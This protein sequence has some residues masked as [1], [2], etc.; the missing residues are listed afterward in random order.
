MK[1]KIK[2]IGGVAFVVLCFSLA[3]LNA[4][5]TL[6][7]QE[8]NRRINQAEESFMDKIYSEAFNQYSLLI[9][10]YEDV[11]PNKYLTE[12]QKDKMSDIYFN[13]A[14]CAYYLMNNDVDV[15]FEQ[16]R[17]LFPNSQ[18]Q[19]KAIFYVANWYIQKA[20]Y[21]K[22]LKTYRSIDAEDL[23]QEEQLEYYYKIGYCY[24]L[25]NDVSKAKT[26]FEKVK[27]SKSKYASPSK[28]Y[29]AH[30]LYQEGKY[31]LA[32]K[33][34]ETLRTNRYFKN[35]VPYYI[36]QIYYFQEKYDDIINLAPTLSKNAINSKRAIEL[37]RMLGD[38]YYKKGQYAQAKEYI[39][40]SIQ[41]SKAVNKEDN[42]LMGYCLMQ[43][44][45]TK[46][47]IDYFKQAAVDSDTLGQNALYYL[48]YCYLQNHDT[49]LAKNAYKGASDMAF[50]KS[51]QED[52]MFTY[53]KL[54]INDPGPYNEAIKYFSTYIKKFPKS[55][56]KA[57]A[58]GYLVQLYER[59]KNY[60]DA[61][62]LL[63][64]M[65]Q[66]DSKINEIYQKIAFNRAVE[67]FNSGDYSL[68]IE[69]FNKSLQ[70]PINNT[71]TASAYYLQ[72][73]S[74]YKL[75]SYDKSITCLN[76]FYSV[77]N[78]KNSPYIDNADYSMGYN[79]FKQK[80][81]SLAKN[82]FV[83]VAK[84]D[85]AK[86]S[87]AIVNDAKLR[88]ADCEYMSKNYSKAVE[89]Y[90]IVI[91]EGR[92][93]TDYACYQKAMALGAN[94]NY[95]NKVEVLL[96]AIKNYP[97]STYQFNM[98]YE[99][100]GSYLALDNDDKAL[101]TY[102]VFVNSYPS[103]PNVKEALG[104]IGMLEYQKG[105]YDKAL[106]TL[107]KLV[108]QYPN[109]S[110]SKAALNII[111]NIYMD[112]NQTDEYLAYVSEVSNAKVSD[113]EKEALLYQ[114]AENHYMEEKYNEAIVALE[115]YL[116]SFA[117]TTNSQNAVYMLA[118]SYIRTSDSV[119]AMQ[120][121]ERFVTYPSN[122]NT[123]KTLEKLL[124]YYNGKD[125]S[126]VIQY[127]ERLEQ[128]TASST[129]KLQAQ[130]YMMQAYYNQKDYNQAINTASQILQ[131]QTDK[132]KQEQA[133]YILAKSYLSMQDTLNAKEY[134]TLLESSS[135]GNLSAEA[136]YNIALILYNADSLQQAENKIKAFAKNPTDEYYLAKSFIIWADIFS[137]KGNDFQAKQTLK[138]I[139]DNYDNQEVVQQAQQ[140]YQAI[141]DKANKEKE[142]NDKLLQEQQESVDEVI[143][144]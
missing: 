123:E 113:T 13:R 38:A 14:L 31:K 58:Q 101:E 141:E 17:T 39:K 21:D 78:Y 88:V 137:K 41:N 6:F 81:Y 135:N 8:F 105:Q 94:G 50:D 72:A 18:K 59:T 16:Y 54:C 45:S 136:T 63:D 73:E 86:I 99:L 125:D 118:D 142:A 36:C 85:K 102:R 11:A 9:K 52:A 34:F 128:M 109:T 114:T 33:E 46:Q 3:S 42:Y 49:L 20:D 80:K 28:Y 61:L 93:N 75:H 103:S 144:P 87:S 56:N 121:Y 83:N 122:K 95:S 127:G 100:A 106:T 92:N 43:L 66:R 40:L 124:T 89:Y 53:A 134:F 90:D 12:N 2:R 24:F 82:Y 44:D 126:K 1:N 108:R 4:Q 107:D 10:Q 130:N 112:K 5:N 104:K 119:K 133:N 132:T 7:T 35:I 91:K 23:P 117:Q 65:Q 110:E 140:A 60:K 25:S 79:L 37:N 47:A 15:L 138:S 69:T 84:N 74:Y 32:L 57:Q 143:I 30:I 139:I 27:D 76:K 70:Y 111:K 55:T 115:R 68:A 120:Y 51:L 64:A 19:T 22:A 26:C 129:L 97:T 48:G 77:P 67:L 98:N 131:T 96:S 62:T 116:N 71:Y 29:Y